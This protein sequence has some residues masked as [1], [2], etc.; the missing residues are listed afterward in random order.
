MQTLSRCVMKKTSHLRQP[1]GRTGRQADI[2][3]TKIQCPH[4][5]RYDWCKNTEVLIQDVPL[6]FS[7]PRNGDLPSISSGALAQHQIRFYIRSMHDRRRAAPAE[8]QNLS[9]MVKR[10]EG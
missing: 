4:T 7:K 8:G 1:D 10:A 3:S 9:N 2:N 6:A 5:F